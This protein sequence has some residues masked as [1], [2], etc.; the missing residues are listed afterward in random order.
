[1]G[2]FQ[3]DA[4]MEIREPTPQKPPVQPPSRM[5]K[6]VSCAYAKDLVIGGIIP[7]DK[8]LFF[9]EV[10]CSYMTEDFSKAQ[11]NFAGLMKT[12]TIE[13]GGAK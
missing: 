8:M 11:Q 4:N 3:E 6:S 10:F 13:N 12:A 1:M 9:A 7:M 5:D 2:M